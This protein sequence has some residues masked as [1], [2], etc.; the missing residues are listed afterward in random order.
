MMIT[1]RFAYI[2]SKSLSAHALTRRGQLLMTGNML[3]EI[4][5]PFLMWKQVFFSI[6][7]A[8]KGNGSV[9]VGS[10]SLVRRI[11][12]YSSLCW[13][14]IELAGFVISTFRLHDEE[15]QKLH[16]PFLA[17]ATLD[18]VQVILDLSPEGQRTLTI[19]RRSRMRRA[20]PKISIC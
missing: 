12:H 1:M 13:Q 4:I 18:L 15:V 11:A 14:A 7:D 6:R 10:Y 5:D 9:E 16:A 19:W 2:A 20:L 17:F 8:I 3:F